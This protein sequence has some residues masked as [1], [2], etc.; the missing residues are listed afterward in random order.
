[1]I[2]GCD[3]IRPLG[4]DIHGADM[5]IHWDNSAIPWRDIYYTTKDAFALL[6]CNAP[7][8][9]ETKRMKRIID[10]KYS[11]A[12]LKTITEISTNI[13]PK[14][15]NEL[16]TRLKKYECLFDGNIGTWHGNHYD[17][18]LKPDAEPCHG[19]VFTVPRIHE[20]TFKQ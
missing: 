14:E 20:L 8:K 19:K 11:K 17:I 7:L 9:Y 4:I 1:M 16:Y 18:K 15:I 3:L 13:Y 6:Q 12:D 2:I 10:A 5:I